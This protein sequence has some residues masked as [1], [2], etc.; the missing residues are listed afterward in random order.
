ALRLKEERLEIDRLAIG[1]LEGANISATGTLHGFSGAPS[2][3]FDA[4]IIA[5]DL[6]PLAAALADRFADNPF[7]V[8]LWQ[9]A[10]AYPGLYED[11][12]LRVVASLAGE[13]A[14]AGELS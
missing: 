11:S 1:G 4:S 3:K 6:A 9:R 14:Q 12:S 7:A 10:Q 13:N 8:G 2:G 5:A